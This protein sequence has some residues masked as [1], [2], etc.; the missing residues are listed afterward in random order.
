MCQSKISQC[1]ESGIHWFPWSAVPMEHISGIL[2]ATRMS[3]LYIWQLAIYLQRS[4]RCPQHTASQWSLSCELRSRTPIFLRSGWVTIG[5]ETERCWTRYSGGYS[6][7]STL[8]TIPVPSAGNS[9]FSVWM[10]T[11][12]VSN[13][14]SEHGVQITLSEATYIV[15]SSMSVFGGS[16]QRPKLEIMSLLTSISAG[17]IRTYIERSVILTPRQQ[18][19]NSGRAVFTKDWLCLDIFAVLWTTSQ[20]PTS[21]AQCRLACLTTSRSGFSLPWRRMNGLTSTMQYRY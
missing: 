7:L 13:R 11:A 20:C 9:S 1:P 19:P 17:G 12:G 16:V 8:N 18:V 3:G 21:S 4:A 5:K 15:S 2:L 6:R 10:G 14:F